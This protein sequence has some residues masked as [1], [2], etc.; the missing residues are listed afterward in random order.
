MHTIIKNWFSTG[1]NTQIDIC[2]IHVKLNSLD[3]QE[4][5]F[6][7]R[8]GLIENKKIWGSAIVGLHSQ[9]DIENCV[10]GIVFE[11]RS[12]FRRMLKKLKMV[13]KLQNGKIWWISWKCWNMFKTLRTVKVEKGWNMLK[14]GEN[15]LINSKKNLMKKRWKMDQNIWNA[16]KRK[17]NF[18]ILRKS[19]KL[20]KNGENPGSRKEVNKEQKNFPYVVKVEKCWNVLSKS[21]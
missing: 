6:N 15:V 14:N 21:F 18:E 10:K 11:D 3:K 2:Y 13:K 20:L 17:K 7:F 1:K 4:L 16:E 5:T 12:D 9:N 19:W 8:K